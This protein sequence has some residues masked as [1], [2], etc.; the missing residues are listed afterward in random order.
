MNAIVYGKRKERNTNRGASW[1]KR[2]TFRNSGI[3]TKPQSYSTTLS[4]EQH[5]R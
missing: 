4:A 3:A 1:K 2:V 5:T